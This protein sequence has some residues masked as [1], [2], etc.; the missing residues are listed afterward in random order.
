MACE[1]WPWERAVG[2]AVVVFDTRTGERHSFP[3]PAGCQLADEEQRNFGRAAGGGRFLVDCTNVHPERALLLDTPSGSL[4]ELPMLGPG[5]GWVALGTSYVLGLSYPTL[6]KPEPSFC[7]QSGFELD[8][9]IPCLAVISLPQK[10]VTYRHES[11][12]PD[13]DVSGAPEICTSLSAKLI[14]AKLTFLPRFLDYGE[15]YYAQPTANDKAIE[16]DRCSGAPVFLRPGGEASTVEYPL[17]YSTHTAAMVFWI[18]MERR[19]PNSVDE[20]VLASTVFAA[21]IQ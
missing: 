5:V 6:G 16:L 13:L 14:K 11:P 8:H 19:E 7:S 1:M 4:S 21:P 15:G 9:Q 10:I 2:G 3:V 17:G 18:A 12:W 20:R